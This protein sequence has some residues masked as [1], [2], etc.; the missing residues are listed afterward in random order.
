[1]FL[2]FVRFLF[3]KK[4]FAQDMRPALEET[5]P[6]TVGSVSAFVRNAGAFF[7]DT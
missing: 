3:V 7:A 5:S 6:G 2:A 1:M 4:R